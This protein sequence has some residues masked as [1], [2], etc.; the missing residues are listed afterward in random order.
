MWSAFD[1]LDTL[2]RPAPISTQFWKAAQFWKRSD[3]RHFFASAA[4]R[5]L[6]AIGWRTAFRWHLINMASSNDLAT[7]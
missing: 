5:R 3:Q 6:P 1:S 4:G 2:T 7:M